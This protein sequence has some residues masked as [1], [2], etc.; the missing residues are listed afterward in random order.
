LWNGGESEEIAGRGEF[1]ML[2]KGTEVFIISIGLEYPRTIPLI[3]DRVH[4]SLSS[5]YFSR[6]QM[7]SRDH[8]RRLQSVFF[9]INVL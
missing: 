3:F 1:A 4:S 8:G 7:I 6:S 5:W 2:A 9:L